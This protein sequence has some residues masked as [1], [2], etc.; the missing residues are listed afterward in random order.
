[1]WMDMKKFIAPVLFFAIALPAQ[2]I[3]APHVGE[4]ASR[5]GVEKA[6]CERHTLMAEKCGPLKG[7]AHFVCDREFLLANPLDCT[8]LTDKA[9]SSCEAEVS[10]FKTCEK[11]PGREFMRCVKNTTGESPMGH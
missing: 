3:A 2:V 10:A 1:M 11:N 7:D 4:C 8:K 9:K 6:R 5:T